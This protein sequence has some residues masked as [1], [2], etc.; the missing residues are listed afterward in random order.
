M[1]R[2]LEQPVLGRSLRCGSDLL[3]AVALDDGPPGPYTGS[4]RAGPFSSTVEC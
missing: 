4:I 2:H 1:S 3:G